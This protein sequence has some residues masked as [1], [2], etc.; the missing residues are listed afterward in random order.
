MNIWV[1]IGIIA[2][3]LCLAIT[4]V[5]RKPIPWWIYAPAV[6]VIILFYIGEL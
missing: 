6:S 5:V 2:W 3:S 1:L 4:L